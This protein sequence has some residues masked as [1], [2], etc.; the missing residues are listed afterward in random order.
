MSC[1]PLYDQESENR[2]ALRRAVT[3]SGTLRQGGVPFE[4]VIEDIS[5]GGVRARCET[6]L[7]TGSKVT[8]GIVGVGRVDAEVVWAN[9]PVYGFSFDKEVP[10]TIVHSIRPADNI[11]TFPGEAVGVSAGQPLIEHGGSARGVLVSLSLAVGET[12]AALVEGA[13]GRS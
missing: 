10:A 6:P 11:A 13:R 3:L 5:R 2:G 1:N 4:I 8:I 9:H 7:A 12:L